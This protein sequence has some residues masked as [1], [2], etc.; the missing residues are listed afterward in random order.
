MS[1][2]YDLLLRRALVAGATALA[3]VC[4]V[5]S[6]SSAADAPA[7]PVAESPVAENDALH[8]DDVVIDVSGG[9]AVATPDPQ[10]APAEPAPSLGHLLTVPTAPTRSLPAT[11]DVAPS[12]Y[13]A[14]ITCDPNTKPGILSFAE[15][16]GNHYGR[17]RFHTTRACVNA[18]SQHH[19]GRALDWPMN[20]YD[21]QD[22]AIGDA[23]ATWLTASDGAVA[24]RFGIMMVIWN[25]QIWYSHKPSTWSAYT[26]PIP[27]TDHLHFSFTWDGAM[28]R[29]S[30]WSGVAVSTVDHGPCR[31]YAGQYAPRYTGPRT[32]ACPTDLPPAPV[33]PY[34]VVLPYATNSYVSLAQGYLG[35]APAD[36]DGTFG[37]GT[38]AALLDYQ[39]RHQL[40]VTGVLD[41]AT[42]ARM[43]AVLPIAPYAQM[44]ASPDVSGDGA[45]DVVVVDSVGRLHTYPGTGAGRVG[46]V[47]SFGTGWGALTV[48][49][50][51][52]WDADGRGDLVAADRSGDLWLYPGTGSGSFGARS[53]IGFGWTGYRIVPAGDVNGDRVMDLLAIDA[54]GTL[55]LYPGAGGGAFGRRIQV[56]N[57]WGE[58]QLHAAGD[59][60]RDGRVDVLGIDAGGYLWFYGGR[61]GG[62]FTTRIRVGNGWNGFGFASGGDFDRNG[63]NDLV[64]RAPD[65]TVWFYPGQAGGAFGKRTQIASGW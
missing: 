40:P 8:P 29:T 1:D 26:G 10:V 49:A 7:D 53:K 5:P 19:E 37:A 34:P 50:P 36:I 11:M 46:T 39:K 28:K 30:W 35:F 61:G 57:G 64:G 20:A 4:S 13:Q 55:W 58:F 45:A 56:G 15:L 42:W 47:R 31:V 32:T 41:N 24:R 25:K 16:V 17:T 52:D 38:L 48:H 22:K 14:T 62:Y 51:G 23:V 63:V 18:D 44:V 60:N 33:S 21:A 54:A 65:G 59:M 6:A 2:R 9:A 12:R 43:V 3:L 27:H